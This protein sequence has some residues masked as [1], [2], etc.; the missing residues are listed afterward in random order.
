MASMHDDSPPDRDVALFER[1]APSY[2]RS[3]LQPL[4]FA[5]THVAVLDAAAAA[6]SRPNDVLD[7]GCGT[8]ALLERALA[9]WPGAHFVGIDAAPRMIAEA[10]H[11]HVG[12]PRFRFEVGDAAELP[13]EA[14]SVDVTFSTLS[15][16]HWSRQTR[17]LR[18]IARVL[19]PRGLFVLADIRPIWLLRPLM[20]RFHDAGARTQLFEGAGLGVIDQRRPMRFGGQVLITVGRKA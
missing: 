12:D 13:L 18:E 3:V 11:K 5:P 7:V 6:G 17:G 14:A 9:A 10:R 2:D 19:R 4:L 20:S 16:H 15:F 1:W 8:A